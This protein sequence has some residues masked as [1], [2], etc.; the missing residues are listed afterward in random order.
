MEVDSEGEAIAEVNFVWNEDV[1]SE[2][3][4]IIRYIAVHRALPDALGVNDDELPHRPDKPA[5]AIWVL[6]TNIAAPGKGRTDGLG[7]EPMAAQP[8]LPLL[9][10]RCGNAERAHD[11]LKNGLANMLTHAKR[12]VRC[13]CS[14]EDVHRAGVQRPYA[15]RTVGAGRGHCPG[16]L[17]ADPACPPDPRG[18]PD[19]AWPPV[20]P[21]EMRKA[22]TE[23]LQ[24]ALESLG[25][26]ST[27]P[28]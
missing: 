5:Y 26:R 20:D 2:R 22:G 15:D 23:E 16:H 12:L 17:E 8:V 4:R 7:P 19:R 24:A 14:L 3:E 10:G 18:P 6:I 9:N 1:Y 28:V 21:Q 13:H 27:A 11:A 25:E